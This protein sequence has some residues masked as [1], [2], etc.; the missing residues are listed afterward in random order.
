[1]TEKLREC[2]LDVAF[3]HVKTSGALWEQQFQGY[4]VIQYQI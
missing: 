4:F 2:H 3:E 1:M